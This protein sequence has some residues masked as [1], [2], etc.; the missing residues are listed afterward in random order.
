MFDQE[1]VQH[2][3]DNPFL[4]QLLTHYAELGKQDRKIWQNRLMTMDGLQ[5]AQITKLHGELL[6]FEWIEQDT[7]A[8]RASYRITPAGV[9]FL[10]QAVNGVEED[11]PEAVIEEPK[12]S[13]RKRS[14]KAANDTPAQEA[15]AAA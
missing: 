14:R 8:I 12:A 4:Q 9:R 13:P 15:P 7:G 10:K 2:L 11:E 1:D 5:P 6:A 3:R